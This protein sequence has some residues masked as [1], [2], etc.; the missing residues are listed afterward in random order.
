[1]SARPNASICCSP[2]LS[3]PLACPRRSAR[4]REH[5][6]AVAAEAVEG[7][8]PKI[9]QAGIANHHIQAERQQPKQAGVAGD[10][11]NIGVAREQRH[12]RRQCEYHTAQHEG[13]HH[14]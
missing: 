1:M 2:P 8:I 7:H 3:V 11:N 9:E 13:V 4:R 12:Q 5:G 10:P 6:I 14:L